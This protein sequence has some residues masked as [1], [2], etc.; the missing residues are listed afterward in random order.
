MESPV[1]RDGTTNQQRLVGKPFPA[2]NVACLQNGQAPRSDL[3]T[4]QGKA[5]TPAAF[6]VACPV[7]ILENFSLFPGCSDDAATLGDRFAT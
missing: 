3:D 4:P 1:P 2:S 7:S 6:S 5:D